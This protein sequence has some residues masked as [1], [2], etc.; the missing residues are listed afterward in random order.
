MI[1]DQPTADSRQPTAG[2]R[3][4]KANGTLQVRGV[5][6]VLSAAGCRLV[7]RRLLSDVL[8]QQ[9]GNRCEMVVIVLR[10]EQ[11]VVDH[12]HGLRQPRME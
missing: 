12:A 2:S 1:S 6:S 10:H 11:H 5:P 7:G 3:Q 9:L 4:P 8:S